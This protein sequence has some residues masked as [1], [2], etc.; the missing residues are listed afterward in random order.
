MERQWIN[1]RLQLLGKNKAGLAQH[2]GLAP[3]RITE[4]L[5]ARRDIKLTEL[6]L[7]ADYLE[8]SVNDALSLILPG[9]HDRFQPSS[10]GQGGENHPPRP[11]PAPPSLHPSIDRE[12][13]KST[14]D[15]VLGYIE[16]TGDAVN[17]ME[18][19][20][21]IMH[22]YDESVEERIRQDHKTVLKIGGKTVDFTRNR[23]GA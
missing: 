7:L 21:A 12:L 22:L 8:L 18:A 5:N 16:A 2:L 13:M 15:D 4:I 14:I 3:S 23:K 10:T 19:R 17:S 9:F 1:Q 11:E 20:D 6:P